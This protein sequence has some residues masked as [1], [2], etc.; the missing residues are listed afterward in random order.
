MAATR[1]T[2]L[3]PAAQRTVLGTAAT[4]IDALAR[5]VALYQD[6]FLAGF[7]LSLSYEFETWAL[8]KQTELRTQLIDL[9]IKTIIHAP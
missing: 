8:G 7:N 3:D 4:A 5:A 9:L 2:R 6:D 1:S